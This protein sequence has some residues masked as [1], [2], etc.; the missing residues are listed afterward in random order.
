MTLWKLLKFKKAHLALLHRAVLR[1]NPSVR[2]RHSEPGLADWKWWQWG[3][4]HACKLCNHTHKHCLTG[5]SNPESQVLVN[6]SLT[7]LSW[8]MSEPP[9][10]PESSPGNSGSFLNS[11][12][13]W[14]NTQGY[15]ALWNLLHGHGLNGCSNK[16]SPECN[17][18]TEQG[19]PR[20]LESTI[21]KKLE[22]T[23][24]I[25]LFHC[26]TKPWFRWKLSSG[27]CVVTSMQ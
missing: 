7:R 6:I 3:A 9:A 27:V 19:F 23:C 14:D 13:S 4:P 25:K 8:I 15:S 26:A 22:V 12:P 18:C 16:C 5:K 1:L 21:R 17:T 20:H 2:P 24:Q 11:T 10:F